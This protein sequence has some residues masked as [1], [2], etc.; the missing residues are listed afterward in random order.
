ML[1]AD[2][3]DHKPGN[4]LGDRSVCRDLFGSELTR[5]IDMFNEVW[6]VEHTTFCTSECVDNGRR[7]YRDT[8]ILDAKDNTM[9]K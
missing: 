1:W 2:F 4:N 3:I 5:F 6:S 7:W 8:Y 9:K